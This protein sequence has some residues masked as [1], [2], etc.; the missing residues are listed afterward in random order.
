MVYGEI[1]GWISSVKNRTCFLLFELRVDSTSSQVRLIERFGSKLQFFF[2]CVGNCPRAVV[3][4]GTSR[5]LRRKV[6]DIKRQ[7]NREKEGVSAVAV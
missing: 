6:R 2:V 4:Y 1:L 7:I 5:R 3:L